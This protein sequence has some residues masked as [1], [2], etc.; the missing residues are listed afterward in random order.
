MRSSAIAPRV[1]EMSAESSLL[2]A[3]FG[4]AWLAQSELAPDHPVH[5]ALR[6]IEKV[7]SYAAGLTEQL[8]CFGQ[9]L[10]MKMEPL[11]LSTLIREHFST[12]QAMLGQDITLRADLMDD[13]PL[14]A[15][16]AE[17]L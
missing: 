17:H 9:R 7:G 5:D 11:N 10:P 8:L 3:L 15:G 1:A 4:Y 14:L 13:L 16:D 6:E 2:T 12:L